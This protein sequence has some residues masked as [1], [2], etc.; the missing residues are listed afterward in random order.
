LQNVTDFGSGYQFGILDAN[1]AVYNPSVSHPI[2]K[3]SVL[4]VKTWSTT[5]SAINTTRER[6]AAL[7]SL[8]IIIQLDTA[9]LDY[10]EAL[11]AVSG[12]ESGFVKYSSGNYFALIGNYISAEDTNA[13]ISAN[14]ISG[15]S[16]NCGT[17]STVTV[18]KTGTSKIL[19][20]FEYGSAYF[21]VVI[22]VST[23]GTKCQTWFKGTKYYGGFQYS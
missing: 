21:L 5:S 10:D 13:A 4:R 12:Y 18:V 17:S 9:I 15:C 16:V 2:T 14:G 3:I 11:S 20:E 23:D 22:P 8:F 6:R 1:R 19:F 7:S